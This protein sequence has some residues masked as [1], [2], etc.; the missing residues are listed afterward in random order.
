MRLLVLYGL[1]GKNG[2]SGLDFGL[3][4]CFDPKEIG[5]A[6]RTQF[7][8]HDE[9][10][11]GGLVVARGF[12]DESFGVM[13]ETPVNEVSLGIEVQC[14]HVGFQSVDFQQACHGGALFGKRPGVKT[15]ATD[16]C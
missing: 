4:F 5:F 2:L 7:I 14:I 10:I 9:K 1:C 3:Q 15:C 13:E 6:I 11:S 8:I 16:F 12:Q